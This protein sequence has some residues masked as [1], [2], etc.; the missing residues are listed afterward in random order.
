M[1]SLN[2][3]GGGAA[4]LT[5]LTTVQTTIAQ[6]IPRELQQVRM[7]LIC[8]NE[9]ND[10]RS[11]EPAA[12]ERF[13]HMRKNS[14]NRQIREFKDSN[15]QYFHEYENIEPHLWFR[16]ISCASRINS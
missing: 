16:V 9:G 15:R 10:S 3:A 8:R 14:G 13:S 2:L 1:N 11:N 12:S 5:G 6:T 4:A 7:T